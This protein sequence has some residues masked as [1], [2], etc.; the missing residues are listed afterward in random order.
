VPEA[1]TLTLLF[2]DLVGSTESLVALGEDRYDAVRDEHDALVGGA[3]TARDGE[4]VKHTGDGY[5]AVFRLAADAVEAAAEI[6][7]LASKRNEGSEVALEVRI[8]ISA[9]DVTKRAGDYQGVAA[10]EAARLCAAAA[11]GQILASETVRSLVG[12]RGRHEFVA[13]GE[14]DLKGLPPLAAVAVRWC[15]DAPVL[16]PSPAAKGNLPASLDRFIG[17]EH[18]LDAIRALLGE[19]RLV[20]LTGPGG[21]GKT[22]LALEVARSIGTEYADGVWL[23]ELASIDDATL[24]AEAT[25]AAL[26]LRS[27]DAGARDVLLSFLAG[28]D[29]LLV[30]DNCEHVLDGAAPLVAELLA[31]CPQLRV[32]STSREPLGVSGEAE[33]AV[34]GLRRREAIEL[35]AERVPGHRRIDD[36]DAIERICDSLEG[37][38]LAIELAAAKL[39]VLSPAQL[40]DRLDNQ[41]AVLA[42]GR[43]TAPERQRTL[44][45]TLDW[46]YD[47]LDGDQR[48]MLRRLGIFAGGFTPNAA[49]QVVADDQI[50]RARVLDLLE[51]LVERSLLTRVPGG[52]GARFRLLEPIRQYAA[53]RLGESGE[54]NALAQRHLDWVRR[55]A[56]QAFLEFVVAQHESTVRIREEHANICQ[57]LEFAIGSRDGVTA[58]RIID[59]L[60]YPWYTVGQPDAPLWCE[61]V[62]AAVPDDASAVT[63][64][65]AMVAAAM[66]RQKTLQSDA[67][68]LLLEARQLYR[69]AQDVLGEAWALTW[70]GRGAYWRAPASA[71]PLFEEALSRYRESDIAAGTGW[72]LTF[73]ALVALHAEDDDLARQ[74]AEEAVQLGRSAHIDQ[75]AAEGLRILAILDSHAGDFES[76]DRRFAE[77]IAIIEAAGDSFQLVTV[78]AAAAEM[79]ASCGDVPRAASHLAIGAE[80]AGQMGSSELALEVILS[81]AYVAYVDGRADD[82]AALFGALL[83]RRVGPPMKR[84]RPILQALEKK[85]L[86]EEIAAGK[87]LSADHA[88]KRSIEVVNRLTSA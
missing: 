2:T 87:K 64:A 85:G 42:R 36:Q 17:R 86:R 84:F 57:A 12:S 11:G 37:I 13:L 28:R 14:L 27:S 21:S 19:H 88:L 67:A 10:V 81:A 74:R 66:M 63:R 40:A 7:R 33:Y 75:V 30:V 47:L 51:Q 26:E 46:S 80:L 54:Q 4:I 20:T 73:L 77:A 56:R 71:E 48:A 8:G 6:Q 18:D 61:R 32:V 39:R 23:V 16:A 34:E 70:L 24:V 44:R 68:S 41:L 53:E 58:A 49:E 59:A 5:M 69:S 78:H 45:A 55:F 52:L 31:A 22:R 60:G 83:D 35:F 76:S 65:G 15:D 25:M 82:A 9:G 29:S 3:I 43:R 79:A 62:L 50:P 38:P 72:C 1:G